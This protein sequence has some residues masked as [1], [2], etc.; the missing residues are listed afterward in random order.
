MSK[1][2]EFRK[3]LKKYG[4]TNCYVSPYFSFDNPTPCGEI[5]VD[6]DNDDLLNELYYLFTVDDGLVSEGQLLMIWYYDKL[7]SESANFVV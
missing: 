2:E 1:V 7:D 4:V 3:I 5:Q 6:V